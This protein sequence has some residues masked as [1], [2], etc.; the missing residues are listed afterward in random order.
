[1]GGRSCLRSGETWHVRGTLRV[2]QQTVSVREFSTGCHGRAG[3]EEVRAGEEARIRREIIDGPAGWARALTVADCILAYM[4]RPKG[5]SRLD[6]AKLNA[7]NDLI[8]NHL[9]EALREAWDAWRDTYPG[10]APATIVRSRA[11]LLSAVRYGSDEKEVGPPTLPAVGAEK[12]MRVASR[13]PAS[14][15]ACPVLVLSDQGMR[16]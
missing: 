5:V 3:A 14:G 11:Q 9:L 4:G 13:L 15:G 1:M 16:T 10:H 8:G 12:D 6:A 2:G 7:F